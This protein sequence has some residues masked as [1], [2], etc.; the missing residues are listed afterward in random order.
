MNTGKL[1]ARAASVPERII[2]VVRP[3]SSHLRS[4]CPASGE[5]SR[6][7]TRANA[8]DTAMA[9]PA[10]PSLPRRSVAMGVSRLTG[11]NSEATKAKA[12]S[13]RASTA[14][15]SL[16][17]AERAGAAMPAPAGGGLS[18]LMK[19]SRHRRAMTAEGSGCRR[20]RGWGRGPVWTTQGD[21]IR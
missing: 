10:W 20:S 17:V 11:M 13:D 18:E 7:V 3:S 19:V 5:T 14:P 4:S 2:A 15:H 12:P 21:L 1:G 8:P 6:L 16:G 9:C